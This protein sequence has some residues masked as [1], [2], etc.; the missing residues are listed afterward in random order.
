M[1]FL[2]ILTSIEQ[3]LRF[4]YEKHSTDNS[5]FSVTSSLSMARYKRDTDEDDYLAT[6]EDL[7]DRITVTLSLLAAV[8]DRVNAVNDSYESFETVLDELEETALRKLAMSIIVLE[9]S[10]Q[11]NFVI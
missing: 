2:D 8:P 6:L 4:N 5:I 10:V 1:S 9:F 11:L 3:E 7:E